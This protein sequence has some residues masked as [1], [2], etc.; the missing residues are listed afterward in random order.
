[1]APR[2]LRVVA[3]TD[4]LY[5]QGGA[6]RVLQTLVTSLDRDRFSP[7]VF[8]SRALADEVV[9][10]AL[11]AADVP[12]TTIDRRGKLD[13]APWRR[14][15][16]LLRRERVDVLHA[17]KFGA[18]V[19]GVALGRLAR[20][21]VV[22]AHE[23]TW[24]YVGQPVRRFLDRELIG[25]FADAFVAVSAEDRR[26]MIEIE[27]VDPA[28]I[29]L[30]PNG[31]PAQDGRG[32][33]VRAELGILPDDPLLAM[34]GVIRPQKAHPF[35]IEVAASLAEE[36]PRL[37]LLLVGGGS[38]EAEAE[39]RETIDRFGVTDRV[40]LAGRRDDVPDVLAAADVAVLPSDYE[41]QPLALMEYMA[42]ARP[43]VA[44]R[45]GGVPELVED[46]VHA[47]LVE[48][49]DVAGMRAA[50]ASLLR[51][52]AR[53]AELGARAAE[54]R[55]AEFDVATMARRVEGLYEEL[56]ARTARA[57]AEGWSR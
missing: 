6:E 19:S 14:L 47:L 8:C 56:F 13:V 33:D 52:P 22:V 41:G 5:A 17:H 16:E 49:R 43:I 11:R 21:P 20:V 1:V 2:P 38:P 7:S 26:R 34:V 24:S 4:N 32:T 48:P 30:I 51:D 40:L 53:A 31:V 57:R 3:L 28:K 9:L 25:R 12:V 35:L 27:R 42:A 39:L 10:D 46:G 29:R 15:V 23:H 18:N 37:R 55:R 44:T 54:R 50:I 36:F 45:V